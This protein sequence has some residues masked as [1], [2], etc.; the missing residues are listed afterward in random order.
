MIMRRQRALRMEA[1]SQAPRERTRR[2]WR[3]S[4]ALACCAVL[5]GAL[6]GPHDALAAVVT[7]NTS[8]LAG[9]SGRLEFSLL[10]GDR[11]ANNSV[12][13]SNIASNGTFVATDC[14]IGCTGGPSS[15]VLNDSVGLGQLLYDLTLG[16]SLS[17][18]L[19]FTTN[20]GGVPGTDPPDRFALSL[21][22][23]VTNFSLVRTNL[24]FPSDA[25]L[26]VDLTG[27]GVVQIAG[28]TNPIVGLAIPEPGS[29]ALTA[30]AL[31]ALVR[32]R[33]LAAFRTSIFG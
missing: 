11:V 15:F 7:L 12:S 27:S 8:T 31:L 14:S 25:L 18:N 19:S 13:I 6:A 17:F 1:V 20:Y 28:A 30:V 10:D 9:T 24:L 29:L 26:T 16:R 32:R 33:T 4:A 3:H 21:L 2:G 22:D 23:P 5:L